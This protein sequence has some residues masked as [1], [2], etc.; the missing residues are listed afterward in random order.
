[1]DLRGQKEPA[2]LDETIFISEGLGSANILK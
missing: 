1:M 2:F